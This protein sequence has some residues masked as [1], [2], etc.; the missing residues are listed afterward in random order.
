VADLESSK[1]RNTGEIYSFQRQRLSTNPISK[2]EN[3]SPRTVS[4]PVASTSQSV[5][6]I[7]SVRTT[8]P[9]DEI[10]DF[11]KLQ[12]S[13]HSQAEKS[14]SDD[15]P[16]SAQDSEHTSRSP[17]RFAIPATARR[18]QLTRHLSSVHSPNRPSGIRKKTSRSS[19]IRPP[20]PTFIENLRDYGHEVDLTPSKH[21]KNPVDI[22]NDP[23][24]QSSGLSSP[25]ISKTSAFQD[26]STVDEPVA[27]W[28]RDSDQLADELAAL[29]MD[30]DPD[31]SARHAADAPLTKSPDV[32]QDAAMSIIMQDDYVLETYVRVPTIEANQ[33]QLTETN[34]GVLIIE[35]EDEDLWEGY[36]QSDDDSDWD[37]EDSNGKCRH[38]CPPQKRD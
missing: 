4:T 18:F 6:G 38:H 29:A 14:H 8:L 28:N 32:S 2:G 7:P 9:G 3:L 1:R 30:L 5:E 13:R 25:Q 35:E 33:D 21:E 31:A 34:V 11:A 19:S 10:D 12:A 20:L 15:T 27:T 16:Q 26:E 22:T 37:E 23:H 24:A 36:M 17:K